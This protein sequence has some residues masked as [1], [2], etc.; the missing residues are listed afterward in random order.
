MS[1]WPKIEQLLM[2]QNWSDTLPEGY[3]PEQMI[4]DFVPVM[5]EAM[6]RSKT[7]EPPSEAQRPEEPYWQK[8]ERLKVTPEGKRFAEL[9]LEQ[10]YEPE[11]V[12]AH[13]DAIVRSHREQN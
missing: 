2:E 5:T 8:I 1:E 3:T 6:K 12:R 13:F 4:S 7:E 9:L 10:G 11:K